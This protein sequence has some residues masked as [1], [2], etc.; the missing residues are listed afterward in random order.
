[1]ANLEMQNLTIKENLAKVNLA[2]N[3]LHALGL[4]VNAISVDDSR[5]VIDIHSG[6]GCQYLKPGIA[7][8]KHSNGRRVV[9]HE[10]LTS[11]CVVRWEERP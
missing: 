8:Y 9:E 3:T 5:P 6:H 4:T 7:R 10:T 11:D 1:M 2:V